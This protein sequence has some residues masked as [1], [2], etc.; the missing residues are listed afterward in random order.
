M[1]TEI[2]RL[3]DY[4]SRGTVTV[5]DSS[6]QEGGEMGAYWIGAMKAYA[7]LVVV[8]CRARRCGW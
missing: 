7:G 8:A 4:G 3:G 2:G 5:S 1:G 6:N